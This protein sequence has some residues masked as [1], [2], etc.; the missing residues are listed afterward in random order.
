VRE[1]VGEEEALLNAPLGEGGELY[2]GRVER[3]DRMSVE[4]VAGELFESGEEGETVG[5][6]EGWPEGE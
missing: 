1:T 6:R 4:G 5:E 3:E 2:V